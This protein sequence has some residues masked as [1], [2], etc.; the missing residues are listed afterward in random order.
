MNSFLLPQKNEYKYVIQTIA[1]LPLIFQRIDIVEGQTETSS[2]SVSEWFFHV[3][4]R[5]RWAGLGLSE[6]RSSDA[7][8][9]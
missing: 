5:S 9:S 8:T 2:K 7:P 6:Q 3:I 1:A 4:L